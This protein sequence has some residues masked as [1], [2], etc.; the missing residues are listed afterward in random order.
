MTRSLTDTL[1]AA[2]R[3][4]APLWPLSR[5]VAVNPYL[6]L[7][8]LD[9]ASAD[10]ALRRASGEGLTLPRDNYAAAFA[11]GSLTRADLEEAVAAAGPDVP[12]EVKDL[13]GALREG[14]DA[15]EPGRLERGPTVADVASERDDWAT[16]VTET[17]SGF[18]A[19]QLGE[20]VALWRSPYVDE[21]PYEAWRAQARVDRTLELSGLRGFRAW[22]ANLPVEPEEAARA[23]TEA[24]G[25]TGEALDAYLHR[26]AAGL[27]GW[28][29]RARFFQWEAELRGERDDRAT[30]L[31]TILLVHEHA[32]L[33]LIPGAEER[34]S[35]ARGEWRGGPLPGSL[36]LLLHDAWERASAR[37]LRERVEETSR[38][39]APRGRPSLQ[40]AFCIDVRSETVR[41]ALESLDEGA[42]TLGFAGFFGVAIELAA[43]ADAG[44]TPRCPALLAPPHR[45]HETV[46]GAAPERLEALRARRVDEARSAGA[47]AD[48]KLG[49]VS[50]FGFVEALGLGYVVELVRDALGLGARPTAPFGGET[51]PDTDAWL[52]GLSETQRVDAAEA[53]LRGMSLTQRFAQTVLLVGHGASTRNNP[54]HSALE[55]GACGAHPG[56]ANAVVAAALLNDAAVRRGLPTRGLNVPSDTVFVAALHDTTTDD[57]HVDPGALPAPTLVALQAKLDRASG[58]ARRERAARFG[59]GSEEALRARA[60]DWAQVRPEWGLAGCEALIVAPR[61]RTRRAD[62][63]GRVFLH[64]YEWT[65][66]EG[67][68]VLETLMTAPMVVAT[69]ISLQYYASAVARGAF[70]SGD[71][72]LHDVVAGVGVREGSAGDLRVGLPSQS[73]HDGEL[74]VHAPRRLT[75]VIEAPVEAMTDVIRRHEGVR[76]LLD[77]GWLTLFAMDAEGRFSHRYEGALEWRRLGEQQVGRVA[78]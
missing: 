35:E 57:L 63:G 62:L 55:C 47:W 74:L 1:D 44:G 76:E 60:T 12:F 18:A 10:T 34:W 37:A 31:L 75:V 65:G 43:F 72:T 42:E 15:G 66:D 73:V 6:G 36:D 33:S 8:H 52:S 40:A 29:G 61:H 27:P 17:L 71:K 59:L 49:P 32:L 46:G 25:L 7:S 22:A 11:S 38:G 9:P 30:Q 67:F 77:H 69:W 21:G 28:M 51:R 48:F 26:L 78:A 5:F 39:R 58:L 20:A 45:V 14:N 3:K 56:D 64:D 53:I 70:G 13:L 50:S 16:V 23:A 68:G 2:C 54:Y 24:L 19:T 4:V 41:R